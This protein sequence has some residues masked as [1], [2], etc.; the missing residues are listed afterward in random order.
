MTSVPRQTVLIICISVLFALAGVAVAGAVTENQSEEGQ[1][2]IVSEANSTNYLAP[3]VVDVTGE[4][5][6]DV[7]MDASSAATVAVQEIHNEHD[8]QTFN[9]RVQS[10]EP[11][12]Q[13]T[14]AQQQLENITDRLDRLDQQQHDL[15]RRYSEDEISTASLLRELTELQTAVQ[16]QSLLVDQAEEYAEP[17]NDFRIRLETIVDAVS[18][19]QPVTDRVQETLV[20]NSDPMTVFVQ[21]ANQGLVLATVE[22]GVH[23]R[24]A[25]LLDERNIGSPDQF[26]GNL[27]PEGYSEAQKRMEKLYPWAYDLPN[28]EIGGDSLSVYSKIYQLGLTHPHG[29]LTAYFDGAT[30]NIFHE[31]QRTPVGSMPIT[32]TVT[33]TTASGMVTVEGTRESG[34]LRVTVEDGNQAVRDATVMIDEQRVGATGAD[35]G[36]WTVQP[37]NGLNVSVTLPDGQNVTVNWTDED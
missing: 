27:S 10:A 34:P 28:L 26:G 7:S 13:T 29:E 4:Q 19:E 15:L 18:V 16:G 31:N 24:Q 6:Q 21:S 20:G 17:S 14:I 32:A 11:G 8:R 37:S 25:T 35:G 12:E 30:R 5:Y 33:N 1:V 22:D 9:R 36:L 3:T 23:Y 2:T